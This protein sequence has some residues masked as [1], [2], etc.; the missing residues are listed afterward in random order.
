M[1]FGGPPGVRRPHHLAGLFVKSKITMT[2]R[3]VAP[4]TRVKV[5]EDHK[6]SIDNR[7]NSSASIAREPTIFL[8]QR[9]R[10]NNLSVL[11]ETSKH[12]AD[13]VGVD[14]TRFRISRQT[15]PAQSIK[16]DGAMKDVES[17]FPE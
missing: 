12:A 16:R 5:A 15:G 14:I 1:S 9:V 4:P 2:H 3:G 10:P 8:C 7:C 13:G 17:V 6:V 11:V